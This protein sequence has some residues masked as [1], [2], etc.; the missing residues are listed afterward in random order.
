MRP[1]EAKADSDRRVARSYS[2][3]VITQPPSRSE[4][5]S[6]A[7]SSSITRAMAWEDRSD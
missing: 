4:R 6:D 7:A 5:G 2:S 3:Q 1:L